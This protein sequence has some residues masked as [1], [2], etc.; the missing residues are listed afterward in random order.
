M[1]NIELD[2]LENVDVGVLITDNPEARAI[3][4]ADH[5]GVPSRILEAGERNKKEYEKKI[6]EIFKEQEVSLVILAGFMRIV[7]PYLIEKYDERMMNIHPSLLPAFKGLNAQKKALEYGVKVSGCTVHYVS[8]EVDSGPIIVQHPVPVK[9][10][11]TEESL[12]RRILIFEHR[13]YPKAIQ[14]HAD[15]ELTIEGRRV[16]VDADESWEENWEKRQEGF[17]EHQEKALEEGKVFKEIE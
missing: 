14:L 5:Y 16:K 13:V 12:S 17:I 11:D 7:S 10:E 9:K 1:K 8:K 4:V 2:V 6:H 15:D 3:K